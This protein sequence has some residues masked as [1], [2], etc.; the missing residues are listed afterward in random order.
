MRR[1][2]YGTMTDIRTPVVVDEATNA[3]RTA[4][5]RTILGWLVALLGALVIGL[6]A[7]LVFAD[8]P[9]QDLTA[10]QQT[11]LETIDAYVDAWNAGDSA[12]ADAL[13]EP[14]GFLE[15]VSGRWSV[16]N[17][18]HA[19]YIEMLH[20]FGFTIR[21]GDAYII[22]DVVLVNLHYTES[23]A[24]DSA[25]VF[26]MSSNGTRIEQVIER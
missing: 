23:R 18:D 14:D 12:A 1:E 17:G 22:N 6:T 15:D 26:W 19:D 8:P 5:T 9:A 25:N 21:R 7:W 20:S 11:M 16:A 4:P 24:V 10:E 13:M 2:G 3:D